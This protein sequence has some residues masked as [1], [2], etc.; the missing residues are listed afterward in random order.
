MLHIKLNR[1]SRSVETAKWNRI[2]INKT[3]KAFLKINVIFFHLFWIENCLASIYYYSIFRRQCWLFAYTLYVDNGYWSHLL[4]RYPHA[5]SHQKRLRRVKIIHSF[6]CPFFLS[7]LN[8]HFLLTFMI[9]SNWN[10]NVGGH[11]KFSRTH[12]GITAD[13][14]NMHTHKEREKD[15][16]SGIAWR[17][18]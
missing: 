2:M 14:M 11:T 5:L 17:N 12:I 7:F 10:L 1:S 16:K 9:Y 8:S 18:E 6:F 15:E 13:L 4:K 3:N